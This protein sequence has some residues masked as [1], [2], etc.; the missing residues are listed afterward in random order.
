MRNHD[1]KF[2]K[3][4]CGEGNA[5]S[6][7]WGPI[8]GGALGLAG[9]LFGNKQDNDAREQAAVKNVEASGLKPWASADPYMRNFMGDAEDLYNR[10]G[11]SPPASPLELLGR[12]NTLEY[13]E[14]R[15]PNLIDESQYSWLSGLNPGLNPYV[16]QMIQA[17]Q[18]D[19][20]QDY[21]RNIMPAISDRAQAAGGYG[22]SRQGVAQG[23]ALEGLLEAQGDVSA[24]LLGDAF[25]S[26][27][28]HQRAAW[29]A[30]PS[31]LNAGFMPSDAQ[32]AMGDKYRDDASQ[33]ALNLAGYGQVM[34]PFFGMA[35]GPSNAY[36]PASSPVSAGVGG[37][38]AGYGAYDAWNRN[39][40]AGTQPPANVVVNP[41]KFASSFDPYDIRNEIF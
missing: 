27:L 38:L 25:D 6:I 35:G 19:L 40:T 13:A 26:T 7:A 36:S 34:N 31:M 15:L 5:C 23:I 8:I 14:G 29:N 24:R 12:E 30:A 2:D 1:S 28:A 17:A 10:G 11:F 21:L 20:T 16:S 18:N 41:N 33:P 37:A 39:R 9:S 4:E 3:Y 22:G 32:M